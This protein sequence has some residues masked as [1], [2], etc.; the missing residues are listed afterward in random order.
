MA[1]PAF[2]VSTP[3]LSLYEGK[4]F[5]HPGRPGSSVPH[6]PRFVSEVFPLPP[7]FV[8]RSGINRAVDGHFGPLEVR[9]RDGLRAAALPPGFPTKRGT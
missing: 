9:R 5:L 3:E 4:Y 6:S 2:L 7:R 8:R 1:P